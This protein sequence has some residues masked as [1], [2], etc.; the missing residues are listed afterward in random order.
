MPP[1]PGGGIHS[2]GSDIVVKNSIVWYNE[3]T[4][5]YLLGPPSKSPVV[6]SDIEGGWPGTGNL[7]ADLAP[8]TLQLLA[9][10]GLKARRRPAGPQDTLGRDVLA[11][12]G[13]SSVI[14]FRLDLPQDH[15]RI[16]YVFS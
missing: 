4:A 11:Q 9:G 2:A 12:D 5:V 10:L 7:D 15:D 3:G 6:Y 14:P 16:P 1:L 8:I 13:E